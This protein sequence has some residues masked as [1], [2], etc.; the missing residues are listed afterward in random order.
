MSSTINLWGQSHMLNEIQDQ[1]L[2]FQMSTLDGPFLEASCSQHIFF[3]I[4][5][6]GEMETGWWRR[7][8]GKTAGQ[9][10][11]K[12]NTFNLFT[13]TVV[14]FSRMVCVPSIS[15]LSRRPA[16][17]HRAVRVAGSQQTLI[18]LRPRQPLSNRV[19]HLPMK[20]E[21]VFGLEP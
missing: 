19:I 4:Q 16:F 3:P 8:G 7:A 2:I 6:Y 10:V 18:A 11:K 12:E 14:G 13:I 5:V 20:K 1:I 21:M 15:L 17:V 9:G